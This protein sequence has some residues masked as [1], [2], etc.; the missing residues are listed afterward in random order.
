M[1]LVVIAVSV[2]VFCFSSIVSSTCDGRETMDEHMAA[3]ALTSL[4]CSPASPILKSGFADGFQRTY[5][6]R[7]SYLLSVFCLKLSY[8][9]HTAKLARQQ[10]MWH[11]QTIA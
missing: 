3:L 7:C 9:Q 5:A 11:V 10:G 1:E 8:R 2:D 4:S 6:I